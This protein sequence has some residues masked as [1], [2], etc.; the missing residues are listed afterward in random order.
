MDFEEFC[1]SLGDHLT[2]ESIRNH[3]QNKMILPDSN[4]ISSKLKTSYLF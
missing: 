2:V 4:Q 3:Y 1:W